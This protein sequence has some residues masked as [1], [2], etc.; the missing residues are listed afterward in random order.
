MRV[1][2]MMMYDCLSQWS[3]V[4]TRMKNGSIASLSLE[5]QKKKKFFFFLSFFLHEKENSGGAE[6]GAP[7][8][9]RSNPFDIRPVAS[10]VPLASQPVVMA[11]VR[12][13]IRHY[14]VTSLVERR[15]R[16]GQ[17][18]LPVVLER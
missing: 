17:S 11:L 9:R 15:A 6:N 4:P 1:E 13:G 14:C 7:S 8:E 16:G 3:H 10:A 5:A 12:C 2:E 18:E